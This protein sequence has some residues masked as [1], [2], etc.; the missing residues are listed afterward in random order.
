MSWSLKAFDAL[1]L[2][3]LYSILQIRNAVFIVEQN[4]AYQDVD[5]KD[6]EAYHLFYT[7]DNAMLAYCRILA[8][9]SSYKEVSIG[10]VLT[11]KSARNLGLGRVLMEK[12]ILFIK[13][14]WPRQNIKI[15]AQEY[16]ETF[17][18]GFGFKAQGAAYLEDN[19]PH[20]SML[21]NL[22]FDF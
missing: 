16:L 9:G 3:E 4:C 20:V 6:L 10:R 21:L 19:I 1:S 5:N 8:P 7:K 13:E 12:S 15:S 17:Y 22:E 18:Q 2:Q 14:K 11:V